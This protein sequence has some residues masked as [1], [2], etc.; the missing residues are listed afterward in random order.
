MPEADAIGC[1]KDMREPELYFIEPPPKEAIT[2]EKALAW[3]REEFPAYS[4]AA[5]MNADTADSRPSEYSFYLLLTDVEVMVKACV[6]AIATGRSVPV[7]VY[8]K[9]KLDAFNEELA[10]II[11]TQTQ[12]DDLGHARPAFEAL[13]QTLVKRLEADDGR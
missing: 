4:F 7:R 3:M 10:R 6:E 9:E 11:A 13:G 12:F 8:P 2:P 1:K 5:R